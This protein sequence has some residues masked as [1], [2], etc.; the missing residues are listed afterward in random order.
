ME[1]EEDDES[2]VRP[3]AAMT[4]SWDFALSAWCGTLAPWELFWASLTCISTSHISVSRH[5]N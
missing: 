3:E 4:E 2:L 1:E 5:A